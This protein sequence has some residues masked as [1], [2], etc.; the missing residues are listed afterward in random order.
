MSENGDLRENEILLADLEDGVNFSY[1]MTNRMVS[2]TIF[3]FREDA[4]SFLRETV[5][6]LVE[7]K[8]EEVIAEERPA[9]GGRAVAL[10][11]AWHH[12]LEHRVDLCLCDAMN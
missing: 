2:G 5:E 1:P 7:Q 10:K 3:S 12:Q 11:P 4:H 8:G 6:K 9:H